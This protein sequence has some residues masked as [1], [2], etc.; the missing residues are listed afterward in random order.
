VERALQALPVMD[1]TGMTANVYVLVVLAAAVDAA[2]LPFPGRIV[3]AGTGA[4][5]AAG[6]AHL[7]L[8]IV[9]GTLAVLAVDHL[10]Y[11]A[12]AIAEGPV[13][14]L[15]KW[16]TA[17]STR[18]ACR[19][20]QEYFDRWGGLTFLVGRF[21]AMV[22]IVAWPLARATGISYPRFLLLDALAATVWTTTWVGLGFVFGPQLT[23]MVER[24][25]LPVTVGLAVAAGLGGLLA[26]RLLRRHQARTPAA[27][28]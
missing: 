4:V 18:S 17:R 27:T 21:V 3:L 19:T 16:V 26:V 5:A 9:L 11:F 23:A 15:V 20:A 22:R 24:L 14:R 28:R 12:G 13:L 10:W 1:L 25:G 8:L 2:A 7:T 6:G